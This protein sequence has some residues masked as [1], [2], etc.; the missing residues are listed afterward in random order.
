MAQVGN[1]RVEAFVKKP[2]FHSEKI[3]EINSNHLIAKIT[4]NQLV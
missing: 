1:P 2:N 4:W 3:E